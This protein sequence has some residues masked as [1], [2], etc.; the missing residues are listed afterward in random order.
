MKNLF[1]DT[2]IWL[3][4]YFFSKDDLIQFNKL[5]ERIGTEINLII[6]SQV[7]NEII[8]NR[9]IKLK[10][11]LG[12][13]LVNEIQYPTF[14]KG[15][16]EY[17][18]FKKDYDDITRRFN[19]WNMQIKEDIKSRN[20][21]ADNTIRE[22]FEKVTIIP[23]DD[24]YEKAVTRYNVGNPPGKKNSY[25]DA[26]NWECLLSIVPDGEDLY[27]ISA[28]KDYKS[29]LFS[30]MLNSYLN[31]EWISRKQSN[32]YYYSNL[33]GFLSKH[34]KDIKLQ[35]EQEKQDL[36][37]QLKR[38]GSYQTTHGVIAMLRKHSGW[39]DTQIE[40][41]CSA[42]E[43]NTQVSDILGDNDVVSFYIDILSNVGID[44]AESATKR[45][46]YSISGDILEHELSKA[47]GIQKEENK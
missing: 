10:E 23:C 47:E 17:D 28:D 9:E 25:G 43:N 36:I 18:E 6:T 13:F 27:F 32:I 39:T 12:K 41:L 45:V 35:T 8:R 20:L 1:I 24:Y 22:F 34:I 33:V 5:K 19:S 3:S 46:L 30:D 42:V 37:E 29:D 21:P 2:N 40:E 11:S 16:D 38:S 44:I 14:C 4:L 15:Y 26:I 7:Y 31:L